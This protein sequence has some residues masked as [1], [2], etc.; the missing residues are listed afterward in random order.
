[1]SALL[2]LNAMGMAN[3]VVRPFGTLALMPALRHP[4]LAKVA[5]DPSPHVIKLDNG[6][7]YAFSAELAGE[8]VK[9][10]EFIAQAL[11]TAGMDKFL[12]HGTGMVWTKGAKTPY[13]YLTASHERITVERRVAYADLTYGDPDA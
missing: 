5:S 9:M 2:K 12:T 4:D 10:R 13:S 11:P 1:M 3:V 7:Y 6:H 8:L